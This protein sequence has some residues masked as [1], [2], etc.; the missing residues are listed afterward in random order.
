MFGFVLCLTNLLD[1]GFVCCWL[2]LVIWVGYFI[3]ILTC[4]ICFFVWM[5]CLG[6]ICWM[7]V[8]CFGLFCVLRAVYFVYKVFW[9]L[10]EYL[11]CLPRCDMVLTW[12]L[13]GWAFAVLFASLIIVC[14]LLCVQSVCL[15]SMLICLSFLLTGRW[16]WLWDFVVLL[17]IACYFPF[18]SCL[19][20]GFWL[21]VVFI[22][23]AVCLWV[24][25]FDCLLSLV[26]TWLDVCSACWLCWL[27]VMLVCF[28]EL[29]GFS[30]LFG[31]SLVCIGVLW[32]MSVATLFVDVYLICCLRLWFVDLLFIVW[33]G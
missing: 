8:W 3:D 31:L 19:V 24:L 25:W 16:I 10:I 6:D 33:V 27:V 11:F 23:T 17:W 26:T 18:V 1:Y 30:V 15:Y 7:F 28:A 20:F 21:L 13:L 14:W 2:I 4:V 12:I 29:S 32:F 9:G 5:I 22:R